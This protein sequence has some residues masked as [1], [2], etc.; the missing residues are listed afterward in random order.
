[1]FLSK[2]L[3]FDNRQLKTDNQLINLFQQ[4]Y[5]KKTFF[6]IFTANNLKPYL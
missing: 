4:R 1:M 3:N 5:F 2:E 6:A